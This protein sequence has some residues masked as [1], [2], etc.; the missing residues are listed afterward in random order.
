MKIIGHRTRPVL[1]PYNVA[2][3]NDLRVAAAKLRVPR[4]G[5][6]DANRDDHAVTGAGIRR[7]SEK[8]EGLREIGSLSPWLCWLRGLDLN[9]RPLE[10]EPFSNRDWSQRATNNAS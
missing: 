9:Q 3:E 5:A 10:Y 4:D 6:E 8:H 2:A 7:V 1:A